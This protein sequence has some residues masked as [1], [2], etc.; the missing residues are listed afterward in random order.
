VLTA[1]AAAPTKIFHP[2]VGSGI[3]P[4]LVEA[5]L[6]KPTVKDFHDVS[7]LERVAD[8]FRNRVTRVLMVTF[9]AQMGANIGFY[10]LFPLALTYGIPFVTR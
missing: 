9:L 3:F 2:I 6:R 8:L 7:R 1:A 4:G 10:V 5:K